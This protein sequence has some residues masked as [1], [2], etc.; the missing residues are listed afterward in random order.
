MDLVWFP[1]RGLVRESNGQ[2][3]KNRKKKG[4]EKEKGSRS[5]GES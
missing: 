2:K 3:L 1:I 4:K 5:S